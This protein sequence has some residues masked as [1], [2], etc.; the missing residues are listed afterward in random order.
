MKLNSKNLKEGVLAMYIQLTLNKEVM[1]VKILL[2]LLL[3]G[4][5]GCSRE[6]ARV[7]KVGNSPSGS[8]RGVYGVKRSQSP[9]NR[10]GRRNNS[11]EQ[12][13]IAYMIKERISARS[14]SSYPNTF[15]HSQA[16]AS[17]EYHIGTDDVLAVKIFQL[18]EP[19]RESLLRVQVDEAGN[20]YLPILGHVSVAGMTVKQVQYGIMQILTEQYIRNPKVDVN[21]EQYNS[22]VV[23]VLGQVRRPGAVKLEHDSSTLLDVISLAGGLQARSAPSVEILRGAYNSTGNNKFT[24]WQGT[25]LDKL[26][27][28]RELVQLSQLFPEAGEALVNPVIYPGD[29][30]K[31]RAATDGYIYLSGEVEKPGSTPFNRP[32]TI[33]QAVTCAGGATNIAAE[34]KCKIIRR[35]SEGTEKEIIVDLK[36]IRD[37]KQDNLL[38]ARNDTIWIPVDPWKKFF[39]DLDQLI[40]RGVRTG[41]NVTYDAGSEMGFPGPPVSRP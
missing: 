25:A 9:N 33:L 18:L 19:G 24:S 31:V 4:A 22:K 15:Q 8:T 39:D 13:N 38:L 16:R 21:I 7:Y 41:M 6:Q 2:I 10:T 5:I 28:K 40:L 23:M 30:V 29:V 37:G 34:N 26:D 1:A 32:L 17:G 12:K 3:C 27:Y 36:K 11:A 14:R 35:T 20:I